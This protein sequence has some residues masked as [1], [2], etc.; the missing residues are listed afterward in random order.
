MSKK[1]AILI[2]VAVVLAAV[3]CY[4]WFDSMPPSKIQIAYRIIPTGNTGT[5]VFYLDPAYPMTRIK[6]MTAADAQS[7]PHPHALWEIVP[8]TKP[9]TKTQFVYGESIPGMKPF[10]PGSKAEALDPGT[11]YFL[12]VNFAKN[13]RGECTFEPRPTGRR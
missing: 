4:L 11:K 9:V 8:E 7:N 10:I 2:F 13:V 3:S 6:V 5:I 1:T 12:L